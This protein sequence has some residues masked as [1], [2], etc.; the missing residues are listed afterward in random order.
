MPNNRN[1]NEIL[2]HASGVS[3]YKS[4]ISN[5]GR[6]QY[7]HCTVEQTIVHTRREK[8]KIGMHLPEL[9]QFSEI[10]RGDIYK[11]SSGVCYSWRLCS[12]GKD[13]T[14]AAVYRAELNIT[15]PFGQKKFTVKTY[16]GR[17]AMKEW[18]RDFLRCSDP[19]DWCRDI[20][21]FGYSASS[22]PLLIFCGELVPIA[23]VQVP[24]G[25]TKYV[26][27]LYFEG[28]R[29]TL[30]CPMNEIWMDPTNG[31]FCRGPAGPEC[32]SWIDN[33]NGNTI[34]ADVDFLEA[35]V[36]VRYFSSAKSDWSSL[37]A[38]FYSS[39][40]KRSKDSRSNHPK[41]ISSL[42]SSTIAFHRNVRWGHYEGCLKEK[43][44]IGGG[45]TRFCLQ[46]DQHHFEVRSLSEGYSWLMQALSIFHAH[47]ISLDEDLFQ[48][49]L[50]YAYFKLKGTLR[51]SHFRERR[52]LNKPIYFF[53]EACPS[54]NRCFYFW[55]HDLNGQN[56]LSWDMYKYLGL[57]SKLSLKVVY[58]RYAWPTKIYKVL[59]DYQT[60][61]GFD[62]R[63]TDFAQFMESPIWE[64][65]L[66]ENQ[67]QELDQDEQK[68]PSAFEKLLLAFNNALQCSVEGKPCY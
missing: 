20:P 37:L 25:M 10:K 34:P 68:S 30:G 66:P 47:G 59:H 55:S 58:W 17:N 19:E 64:V 40:L 27:R 22:V 49:K 23:H 54:P 45:L 38:L 16:R 57:P 15:G 62:P 6:D 65:V 7:N 26:I 53:L 5:V 48:Y 2:N 41:V 33:L 4:S 1:R 63:T 9:S 14:E 60:L 50:V 36:L 12:N 42:S 67:F 21:L 3:I 35:D 28:L 46:D 13:D 51:G 11:D 18:R 43:E 39:T 44:V 52:Q 61:R 29:N 24:A 8:D 56:P 31:K 32:W